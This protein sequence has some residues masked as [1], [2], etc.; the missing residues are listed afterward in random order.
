MRFFAALDQLPS[1]PYGQLGLGI[2]SA[3]RAQWHGHAQQGN[4]Q[5]PLLR[6]HDHE[7]R[8]HGL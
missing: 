8:D 1:L 7:P 5:S 6:V 4:A 3:L 2:R